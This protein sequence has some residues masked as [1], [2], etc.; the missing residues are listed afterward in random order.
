[1]IIDVDSHWEV[2][3]FAPGEHPFEPWLD[4]LPDGIGRLANG[5]AGDLLNALP[6]SDRPS[7]R[8]LLPGLVR[9]AE[10]RG[11]PV[12]LHPE[13][14]ATSGERVAW[15]DTVGIDH[16]LVNPGGY[17]QMLEFIGSDRP[18][19]VRRCN[20]FLTEQLSDHQDRL[21]AVA[22]VDFEDLDAAVVELERARSRGAR[23]FYLYTVDGR[24]PSGRSPGHPDWDKVW[25]AAVRLGMVSVIH[26]GNTR[27]DFTGWADIGWNQPGSAGVGGLVRLAN[28]QRAHAAQNLLSA[29]LYGGV[30][31]RHP[32]LTVLF[33]ELRVNWIPVFLATLERQSL[34][35]PALG[36]WPYEVSGGDMLRKA[37][38]VTPLIGFGDDE[39]LDLAAEYP[40][41]AVF[42]S[43]YP[44]HEGNA[45][46]INLFG[47]GLDRLEPEAR[48]L[49]MGASMVECFARTGDPLP[50]TQVA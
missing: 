39:A 32:E 16:C 26:V 23:A 3:H 19:G 37:V 21:H 50:D 48:D 22:V 12:I 36:D 6:E 31:A 40:G 38:R 11:G 43:D 4:R 7:A 17:W 30:F 9:M 35:S 13:H 46:P 27:T 34:S 10:Q 1:M 25:S 41:M 44:H 18:A 14:D 20:D 5:I 2:G 29:M 24:P 8:E 47:D 15:M 33:E 45:D 49:F 42:S 28:T